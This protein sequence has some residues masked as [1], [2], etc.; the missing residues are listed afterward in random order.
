M[1]GKNTIVREI[2]KT[3]NAL[4]EIRADLFQS[5]LHFFAF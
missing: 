5:I 2:E 4:D 1:A 3:K